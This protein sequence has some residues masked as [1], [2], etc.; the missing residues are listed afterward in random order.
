ML[1][2]NK[3]PYLS[4][5]PH[6]K[7]NKVFPPFFF[8]FKPSFS[9]QILS[10]IH[11]EPSTI[12]LRFHKSAGQRKITPLIEQELS[13]VLRSIQLHLQ[14][15][16]L[17]QWTK[18]HDGKGSQPGEGKQRGPGAP[19]HSR[20]LTHELT[21][22]SLLCTILMCQNQTLAASV[23]HLCPQWLCLSRPYIPS[24]CSK[25][26]PQLP[27]VLCYSETWGDKRKPTGYKGS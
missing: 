9:L 20:Q 3:S 1:P 6:P 15:C 12:C 11:W 13:L 5:L 22:E 16:R 25:S 21:Q 26:T 23:S 27:L 7:N 17:L 19:R 8:F 4:L 14:A 18:N 10:G 24:H 2:S